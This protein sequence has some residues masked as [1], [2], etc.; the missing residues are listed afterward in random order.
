V[1]RLR[2]SIRRLVSLIDAA[3]AVAP[4]RALAVQRRDLKT[5]LRSLSALRDIDV[6]R[7]FIA[8]GAQDNPSLVLLDQELRSRR[9]AVAARANQALAGF[10][11]KSL[12]AILDYTSNHLRGQPGERDTSGFIGFLDDTLSGILKARA[13]ASSI[14][15]GS[16]H[17]L[18]IAFKKLRYISEALPSLFAGFSKNEL[19]AMH[20]FHSLMGQI[21]D[22]TVIGAGIRSFGGS[23]NQVVRTELRPVI[24]SIGTQRSR[25]VADLEPAADQALDYWM[26]QIAISS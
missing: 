26:K 6:T 22:L 18:R 24:E 10:D 13:R 2:T 21:Q 5:Q 23:R 9:A 19:D 11:Q 12:H 16:I 14:D 17:R 15:L 25:L 1:R 8:S 20:R 7:R 4:R 3:Q